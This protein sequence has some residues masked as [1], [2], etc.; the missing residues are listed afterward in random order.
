MHEEPGLADQLAAL[1]E[2]D[3]RPIRR[4]LTRQLCQAGGPLTEADFGLLDRIA[5]WN[6]EEND[7]DLHGLILATLDRALTAAA[8]VPDAAPRLVLYLKCLCDQAWERAWDVAPI[9]DTMRFAV[10]TWTGIVATG[11]AVD[12]ELTMLTVRMLDLLDSEMATFNAGSCSTLATWARSAAETAT[13]AEEVVAAADRLKPSPIAEAVAAGAHR[14]YVHYAAQARAAQAVHD[15]FA[16]GGSDLAGAVEALR[17]A[18]EFFPDGIPRSE[19]RAH[20]YSVEALIEVADQPWLLLEQARFVYLYPFGLYEDLRPVLP[21]SGSESSGSE[22]AGPDEDSAAFA[23]RMVEVAR[24]TADRWRIAGWDIATHPDALVAAELPID[25]M[26]KGSDPLGRQYRGMA[27][28]LPDVELVDPDQPDQDPIT[29]SV[30]LRLS[31]LGNHYLRLECELSE[32]IPQQVYAAMTRVAPEFGD[33]VQLGAP[34]RPVDGDAE[35]GKVWSRLADLA[36]EVTGDV[37]A[38]LARHSGRQVRHSS[39]PGMYH[40]LVLVDRA[41]LVAPD[42]SRTP[43]EALEMTTAV[44]AQPMCHPVRHGLSALAEWLRYPVEVPTLPAV[45]VPGFVGDLMVRTCN[46]TLMVVPASPEYTVN[47]AQEAAEFVAALEG[48]FAGWQDQIAEYYE[49]L[50]ADLAMMIVRLEQR[51]TMPDPANPQSAEYE[52][53]T[54]ELIEMQGAL[55]ARHLRLHRFVMASRL[56]L[57][58]VTSPSLMTSP[59][60]RLII[61]RLLAAAKFDT[62]RS[63]F[64][65]MID[66]VLGDRIG[67]LVDASVR[68]QQER[69]DAL[70]RMV[71]EEQARLAQIERER[72]AQEERERALR[73]KDEAARQERRDRTNQ[74]RINVL[75]GAIAAV[76]FSGVMQIVQAGFDLRKL[77]AI[78]LV[79]VVVL[80]ALIV[81]WILHR[82]HPGS[83]ERVRERQRRRRA[84]IHG[85]VMEGNVK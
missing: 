28:T 2:D 85:S 29:F 59:F 63:E 69:N 23:V 76:G 10:R 46:S 79:V 58:F 25:D 31:E 26:W 8:R 71:R 75:S 66:K 54:Q 65:G 19:L 48:M 34:L 27:V 14:D 37:S 47:A 60:A 77:A 52:R 7:Q 56:S 20:R 64:E 43:V 32:A 80:A 70:T 68:R 57:M 39:R 13:R 55:E 24:Q 3:G 50:Q 83:I 18:E 74:H 82:Q 36:T 72:V 30:Q 45:D 4:W 22:G 11:T 38:E 84:P 67:D 41:A 16:V 61:D 40:V 78:V 73:E 1:A 51:G 35:P 17:T 42:G 53:V 33:L 62:L 15:H 44:G 21:G 81:A 49:H 12:A 9:L 6:A 5:V